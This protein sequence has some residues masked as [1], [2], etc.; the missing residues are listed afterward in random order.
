MPNNKKLLTGAQAV[1][2]VLKQQEINTVFAYPGTSELFLCNAILNTKGMH[3]INGRGDKESAF[4]A[5]GAGL[6][7][8]LQACAILHGARGLTNACG[9]IADTRRNEIST[10][11]IAGLPSLSSQPFLPPHGEYNLIDTIGKFTNSYEEITSLDPQEFIL[12]LG[13]IISRT[14]EIPAGPVLLGIP[15]D[16]LEKKYIPADF[17]I[18]NFRSQNIASKN[19]LINKAVRKI[20]ESKY[21]VILADD[22]IFKTENALKALNNLTFSAKIPVFQLFYSRGPMLFEKIS[23]RKCPAFFGYYKLDNPI[24]QKLIKMCDLLITIEDRNMYSRVVG[25]L[26]PCPKI[27]ITSSRDKTIK[28]NY[29]KETDVI[30]EGNISKIMESITNKVEITENSRTRLIDWDKLR[31]IKIKPD[32]NY[33]RKYSFLREKIVEIFGEVLKSV[34]NPVIVD[35][36]QMFGGMVAKNYDN[37]PD[38]IRIFGDH[39]AFVGAGISYATGLAVANRNLNVFCLLGDQ[40]FVNGFQGFAAAFENKTKCIYIV[41]NNG[42]SVSLFK[43]VRSQDSRA[44]IK[45]KRFLKN[46]P[47]FSYSDIA[48]AIGLKTYKIENNQNQKTAF[49]KALLKSLK[50]NKPV[51]IE[52]KA[53]SEKDA[54]HGVWTTEGNEAK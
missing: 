16:V 54:W 5:A 47:G 18:G 51:L 28:N 42:E 13:R 26:P 23:V 33:P 34:K 10:I 4:M 6:V 27:A 8:P 45:D 12:K 22:Y 20:K 46:I 44:F 19:M 48:K 31:K 50:L 29:L 21:P 25:Q 38:K 40:A 7:K 15:Q 14:K 30:I 1:A 43:Q 39:G 49:R 37:L 24:S 53:P 36:S 32:K 9:A 11:F 41:L 17:N 52:I 3:L 2:R 35:D